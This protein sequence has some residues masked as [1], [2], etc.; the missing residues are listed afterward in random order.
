MLSAEY[1]ASIESEGRRLGMAL[2]RDPQ[3]EVPQYP[4]WTLADLAS[5]TGSIHARTTLICRERPQER[6]SSP[7]P[8][9]GGD[10]LDWYE[11]NLEEMLEALTNADPE[12]EVW[13]LGSPENLGFWERRMVV[14]TGVHRWDAYQAFGEEDRLTDTVARAGLD[15]FGDM[16]HRY[17]G[18]LRP[19]RVRATDL[20]AIWEFGSGGDLEEVVGTASEIYLRLMSRPSVVV[21]PRDWAE[22]VDSLPPTPKP[23]S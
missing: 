3:R 8:S 11:S 15:E 20:E 14:E 9:E 12:K 6:I 22:A 13:A 16:W 18:E 19:L 2:R 4:G 5:H 17:L 21:L 1:L 10:P 23:G 7:K